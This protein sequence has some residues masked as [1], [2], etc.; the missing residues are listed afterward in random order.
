MG[1]LD[2]LRPTASRE[3]QFTVR[4]RA[5]DRSFRGAKGDQLY[6]R[7]YSPVDESGRPLG[8]AEHRTSDQRVFHCRVSATHHNPSALGDA[9]FDTGSRVTLRA[10]SGNP[11]DPHAV[12]IWDAGGSVRV[13][14]VPASLSRTIAPAARA[15]KLQGEVVR[16]LRLGSASGER[17]ALY[18][19]V[20]PPGRIAL[21]QV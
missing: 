9:R 13:G 5:E 21:A 4:V 11:T 20:A 3:A 10:E 2:R 19:L 16:E 12:G 8:E 14:Y 7:G 15:G 6:A 1:L 18:V 17:L